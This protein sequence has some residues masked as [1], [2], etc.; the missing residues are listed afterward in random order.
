MNIV[1]ACILTSIFTLVFAE[2][3]TKIRKRKAVKNIK[4]V[5]LNEERPER[6]RFESGSMCNKVLVHDQVFL[7]CTKCICP[8]CGANVWESLKQKSNDETKVCDNDCEHC[9]LVTCPKTEVD[10]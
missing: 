7:D 5:V 6:I 1:I 2:I 10:E 9:E 4:L 8:K 3:F